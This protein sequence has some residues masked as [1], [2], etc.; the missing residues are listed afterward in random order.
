[1][2]SSSLASPSAGSTIRSGGSP[3]CRSGCVRLDLRST[4]IDIKDLFLVQHERFHSA[5]VGGGES[6]S[7]RVFGGLTDNQMRARPG[8]GLNSLVWLLWHM[9]RTEDVAV[10]LVVTDRRQVLDDGWVRRINIWSRTIG[11]RMA[12][13]AGDGL[14]R[15]ADVAGVRDDRAAPAPRRG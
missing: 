2:R 8:G 10:N 5:E 9:A 1:M 7:D 15:R 3:A 11:T 12:D 14:S 6:Y 4:T 13:G